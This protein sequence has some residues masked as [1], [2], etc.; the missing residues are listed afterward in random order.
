MTYMFAS[1]LVLLVHLA[2]VV[3]VIGGAVLLPRW[4][5]LMWLHLPA[6]A[7]GFFVELTGRAC[8]LTALEN[9]LRQRAGQSGYTGSFIEHYI[10]WLLYPGG[11]TRDTQLF[12]AAAVAV[13]NLV[14]YGW[15]FLR[16]SR[17]RASA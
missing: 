6:A 5:R 10:L 2:F 16:A 7:W 9:L 17:R 13:I 3:F 15:V 12:L 1:S 14:L 4:P 11:L 8:P